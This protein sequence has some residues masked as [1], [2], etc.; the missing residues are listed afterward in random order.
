MPA[1]RVVPRRSIAAGQLPLETP[2]R[3]MRRRGRATRTESISLTLPHTSP[4]ETNWFDGIAG[5]LGVRMSRFALGWR[6]V[7]FI[8]YA[9]HDVDD[10]EVAVGQVELPIRST[11]SLRWLVDGVAPR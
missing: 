10:V 5:H 3:R 1:A 11:T 8:G 2:T 9:A 6:G 4:N 7:G